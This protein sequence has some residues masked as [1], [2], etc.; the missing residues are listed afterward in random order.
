MSITAALAAYRKSAR[1][2]KTFA[3]STTRVHG[4]ALRL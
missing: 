4:V 3:S 1:I 2:N